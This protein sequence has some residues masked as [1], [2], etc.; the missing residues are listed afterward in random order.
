MK[1]V[2]YLHT[3]GGALWLTSAELSL[4]R[5]ILGFVEA[6]EV[7]GGPLEDEKPQQESANLRTFKRLMDKADRA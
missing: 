3:D 6:G 7:S 5:A 4:L 2:G 1:K